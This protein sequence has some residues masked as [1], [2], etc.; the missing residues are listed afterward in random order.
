VP[1]VDTHCPACNCDVR[2]SVAQQLAVAR[3]AVR[4]EELPAAAGITMPSLRLHQL[5]E[6]K[7]TALCLKASRSLPSALR[8]QAIKLEKRA[9]MKGFDGHADRYVIDPA[10]HAQMDAEGYPFDFCESVVPELV[11]FAVWPEGRCPQAHLPKA[12]PIAQPPAGAVKGAKAGKA[13]AQPP[14]GAGVKAGK[15][16]AQPP[17]GAGGA[18]KG[19]KKGGKHGGRG[20]GGKGAGG[21]K[22]G[23]KQN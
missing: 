16:A 5:S 4:D 3:Q 19:G 12:K 11:G 7:I 23:G 6:E 9:R 14:Q 10:Y 1:E 17:Q 15:A 20:K 18:V 22:A 2:V 8:V 21:G 13:A